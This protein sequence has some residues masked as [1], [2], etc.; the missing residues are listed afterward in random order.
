MS[1][2]QLVRDW[3]SEFPRADGLFRRLIWSRIHFP[4]VELRV[5]NDLGP[6]SL[7]IA[8]D[9]GAA[10]GCYCWVLERCS[11]E[12]YAFEPGLEHASYLEANAPSSV[13]LVCAAV[14]ERGGTV[15]MYMGSADREGRHTATLSESNPIASRAPF[16][17]RVDQ[18]SLDEFF[19]DIL[20]PGRSIDLLKVDVEGYENAVLIGAATIIR[21]HHPVIICEIE[22]RHNPRYAEVF[23]M[24]MEVGYECYAWFDGRYQPFS[25]DLMDRFQS[26][27]A[28]NSR[29]SGA[30][31]HAGTYINNFIFQHPLGLLNLVS[32][33]SVS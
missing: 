28:L 1:I 4:E 32:S 12:V 7:D 23:E 15:G 11:R 9:V 10:L 24:L 27:E 2:R 22:R 18:V 21:G 30:G 25:L 6:G 29:L 14:G 3:L 33:S 8:I 13:K 19:R 31:R 20:A 17:R 5:L 26:E 16:V